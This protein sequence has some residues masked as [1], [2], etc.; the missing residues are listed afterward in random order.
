MCYTVSVFLFFFF[1]QPRLRTDTSS[2]CQGPVSL[3]IFV[4]LIAAI[5]AQDALLLGPSIKI[6]MG[7]AATTRCNKQTRSV[8]RK[9]GL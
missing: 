9:M 1:H 7:P 3:L 4:Y 2:S 6:C 8:T 5:F